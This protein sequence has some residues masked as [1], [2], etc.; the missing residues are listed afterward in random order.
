MPRYNSALKDSKTYPY[1]KIE[2]TEVAIKRQTELL[3][4][5]VAH[6][7]LKFSDT[8]LIL[9][10][11]KK[12][13]KLRSSIDF[14]VL[15]ELDIHLRYERFWWISV[16]VIP[17]IMFFTS[18]ELMSIAKGAVFGVIIILILKSISDFFLLSNHLQ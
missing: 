6:T 8:L 17:L 18:I 15:E 2:T 5:K 10:P 16:L 13:K 11:K 9:V 12:I 1:I 4:E 7:R 14:V 3:R